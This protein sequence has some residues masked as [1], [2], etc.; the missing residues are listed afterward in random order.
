MQIVTNSVVYMHYTL[1]DD[2]GKVIDSS[3]GGE[4]LAYLHGGGNIV[5]GLEKALEGKQAGDKLTVKVSPEEGYGVREES[6]IQK[7]PRRALRG[8][9]DLKPGMRF[10]AQGAHGPIEVT[11]TAIQGDMVTVDGN[12][13]LAGVTLN[14][15]VEIT[16][17][18]E[19][20]AEELMHGHVHGAGGHHH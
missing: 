18:R 7:V 10:T 6:A 5:K 4:P 3:S 13:A 11:V 2:A 16:K 20:T 19:A 17:V 8:V 15:D 1:T 9:K 12:H 14:F